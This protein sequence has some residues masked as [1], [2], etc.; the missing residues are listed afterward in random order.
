MAESDNVLYLENG[1]TYRLG[2][3]LIVTAVSFSYRC[4]IHFTCLK[5]T[6]NAKNIFFVEKKSC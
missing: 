6:E 4:L 3:K 5:Q 1:W 2:S